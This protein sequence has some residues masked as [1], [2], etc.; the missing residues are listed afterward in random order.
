MQKVI[1]DTNII[2][3]SLKSYPYFIV[4]DRVLEGYV[5]ICLSK[6]LFDE[7]CEVLSRSKFSKIP[8]FEVNA[9]IVLNRFM[10][11]K[12]VSILSKT[13]TTTDYWN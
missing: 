4:F 6:A 3:S 12:S 2:V 5:Q 8:N 10:N 11:H 1:L 13:Q 9:N 7:Y